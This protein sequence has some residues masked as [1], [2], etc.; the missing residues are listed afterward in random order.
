LQSLRSGNTDFPAI[1]KLMNRY[2]LFRGTAH[3]PHLIINRQ[4]LKELIATL[5]LLLLCSCSGKQDTNQPNDKELFKYYDFNLNV[6]IVD[7]FTGLENRMLILN[8]GDEFYDALSDTVYFV[9]KPKPD[10]LYFIRY[11]PNENLRQYKHRKTVGDTTLVQLTK[12]QIDTVYSLASKVF[13][14]DTNNV[15]RDSIPPPPLGD[16]KIARVVLD[17]K[18]RGDNYQRIVKKTSDEDFQLL[19]NYL[20]RMKNSR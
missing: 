18:F 10:A 3:N 1:A 12:S 17:L 15:S 20:I 7:P 8:G 19:Y 9:Q 5:T 11:N 4:M 14:F 16:A 13:Y 6:D 2:R